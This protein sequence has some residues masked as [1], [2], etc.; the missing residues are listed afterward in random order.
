MANEDLYIHRDEYQDR[1]LSPTHPRASTRDE[2]MVGVTG[3]PTPMNDL[4]RPSLLKV[5]TR[6]VAVVGNG[7][8]EPDIIVIVDGVREAASVGDGGNTKSV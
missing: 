8:D 4:R 3:A 2:A 7:S 6:G 1:L 5:E